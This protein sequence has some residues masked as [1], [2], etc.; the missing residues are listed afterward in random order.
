MANLA[1]DPEKY[2]PFSA[3]YL[4]SAP[5]DANTVAESYS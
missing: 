5:M 4:I 3:D 2:G 1:V